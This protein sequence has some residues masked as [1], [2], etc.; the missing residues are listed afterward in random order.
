ME[1][2]NNQKK[3]Y[4]SRWREYFTPKKQALEQPRVA[5]NYRCLPEGVCFEEILDEHFHLN[6]LVIP[7]P[8]VPSN[9]RVSISNNI[10]LVPGNNKGCLHVCSWQEQ[11]ILR[12]SI[13]Y[14]RNGD[15]Y[16]HPKVL[17]P[18]TDQER[19]IAVC[20]K[21][22][23]TL[24]EMR[25]DGIRT[26]ILRVEKYCD[27]TV[28]DQLI[29]G[30]L[31]YKSVVHAY[32]LQKLTFKW[33][34][35]LTSSFYPATTNTMV[36]TNKL[37]YVC[38]R[39]GRE[40]LICDIA[41]RKVVETVDIP[42]VSPLLCAVDC[43]GHLL[44]TSPVL[45]KVY[46]WFGRQ[47]PSENRPSKSE[48]NPSSLNHKPNESHNHFTS[49]I[50]PSQ[51][52]ENPS[53]SVERPNQ[54]KNPSPSQDRPSQSEEKLCAS[55]NRLSQSENPS[56]LEDKTIESEEYPGPSKDNPNPS[57]GRDV[58][59]R[60]DTASGWTDVTPSD[61][62]EFDLVSDVVYDKASKRWLFFISSE[63]TV[64]VF[65]RT[66]NGPRL[67]WNGESLPIKLKF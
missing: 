35:T 47:R 29:L 49:E 56:S 16:T 48:E 53:S 31:C 65:K 6:K 15:V 11:C 22:I 12:R 37:L 10:W 36:C 19:A 2:N 41:S 3:S 46:I 26:K 39:K 27:A 30:L 32:C 21:G 38:S 54:S 40:I 67:I 20:T 33:S 61:D 17:I 55:E 24:C 5:N 7:F 8:I 25:G 18:M 60:A 59:S 66:T 51:S 4:Q 64:E 58:L 62:K 57:E 50:S 52:E 34:M 42:F 13:E 1:A 14:Y 45:G 9:Y 63:R 43:H 23:P 28:N 44:V